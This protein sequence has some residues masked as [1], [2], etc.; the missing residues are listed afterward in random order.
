MDDPNQATDVERELEKH[1]QQ[2]D[3]FVHRYLELI[4]EYGDFPDCDNIIMPALT[5]EFGKEK[6][7][8]I[9]GD[10]PWEDDESDMAPMEEDDHAKGGLL[11]DADQK[12]SPLEENSG[13]AASLIVSSLLGW[14]NIYGMDLTKHDRVEAMRILYLLSKTFSFLMQAFDVQA[15]GDYVKA[16]VLT[17]RCKRFALWA[18]QRLKHFVVTGLNLESPFD[19]I[20]ECLDESIDPLNKTILEYRRLDRNDLPF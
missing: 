18:R 2:T 12:Q 6:V 13:K 4:G 7:N 20:I 11:G 8:E 19:N 15:E 1:L 3:I 16:I 5:A 9:F 14:C 17:Q 10:A